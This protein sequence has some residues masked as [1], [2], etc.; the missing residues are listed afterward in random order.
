MGEMAHGE[1]AVG[2][3]AGRDGETAIAQHRGGDAER[4]R[5]IDEGIP[6][7]LGVVVGVA[8]DDARHQRQPVS[9]HRLFGRTQPRA[10]GRDL[11]GRDAEVAANGLASRAVE[12]LRVPDHKI[13]HRFLQPVPFR[14]HSTMTSANDET[15]LQAL[16]K[17]LSPVPG[18]QAVVLGGSRARG[19]ATSGSDYDIGLYY[20]A[21]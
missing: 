21:N 13:E 9:L 11:A 1:V 12:D 15:L 2:G 8:V 7:D 5:G 16:V 20:R 6:G 10:D 18:I 3:L 19:T 17:A 4:R 14:L